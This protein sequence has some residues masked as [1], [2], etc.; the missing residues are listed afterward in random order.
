MYP[1]NLLLVCAA[2]ALGG[3][4]ALA[5]GSAPELVPTAKVTKVLKLAGMDKA[6]VVVKSVIPAYPRELRE[7]GI[8][9]IATVDMVIDSTGRVV[10]T[11][12]VKSTAPE[13]GSLALAAAKE[14][15]FVP[16]SAKGRPITTR[17]RVPFEF[18]MPQLVAME[19][20]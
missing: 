13:L 10:A 7:D 9:G 2:V 19:N 15:T 12:L 6:P 5:A 18:V 17:V 4:S 8:Q 3:G 11:E 1:K 20:R 16:A 14:W